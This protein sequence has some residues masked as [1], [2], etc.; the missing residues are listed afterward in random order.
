MTDKRDIT[1]CIKTFC[2]PTKF[3]KTLQSVIDAGIKKINVGYDGP[4][5]LLQLH[6]DIIKKAD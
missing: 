3:E 6:Y 1:A 5:D 4:A 2:R